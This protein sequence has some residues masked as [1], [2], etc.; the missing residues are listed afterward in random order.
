[1]RIR[2]GRPC[3]KEPAVF[4]P[5]V[6]DHWLPVET[7]FAARAG[8]VGAVPAAKA[9]GTADAAGVDGI[10]EGIGADGTVRVVVDPALA[11]D[12]AVSLLDIA[13]GPTVLALSPD[14]AEQLALR[15]G[16]RL[17]ETELRERI[18]RGG[19]VLNDPD[20]LLYLP[21]EEQQRLRAAAPG[22]ATRL[23]TAADGAA[24]AAFTAEAPE[25]DLDEAY[26]ELDH[27]LVTGAF[28]GEELAA[29]AS[30]YPWGGAAL[31]DL[32]VL[33]LPR[34][35]GGG[36]GRAAVRA[37]AAAA[38]ARGH[39]PQYRCQLENSASLALAR[40]AGFAPF[41]RWEVLLPEG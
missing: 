13:S 9:D 27:W 25:D 10:A 31:A 33:T 2:A 32:G 35:R 36:H 5:L 6:T 29:A 8:S 17:E 30:A 19:I 39:E 15:D 38:L 21:L 22:T 28:V 24:F 4:S 11:A 1:V 3:P 20:Q 18:E 26:V 12:R 16:D 23:L 41:G 14:R 34:F 37:L 7:T 40:S